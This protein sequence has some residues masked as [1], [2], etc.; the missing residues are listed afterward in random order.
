M[1]DPNTSVVV[2]AVTRTLA[3]DVLDGA[4]PL[5]QLDDAATM[6]EFAWA[7][8][9]LCFS[10]WNSNPQQ[11]LQ[12][13]ELL[14]ALRQQQHSIAAASA[15][16]ELAALE[17]WSR[18]LAFVVRGEMALAVEGF[19]AAAA[20]FRELGYALHAAQTQVAKIMALSMLGRYDAASDC[21]HAA[22]SEFLRLNDTHAAAKV[23]L[24]LGAL[25]ERRGDFAQAADH[26]RRAAV[27]FARAG[28]T[29]HS[30]MADINMAN[31][32]SSLG[33]F[34]EAD[35]MYA[36]AR[37]RAEVHRFPKLQTL[38][39]E[40]AAL[41]YLARGN[42][43]EA[44]A[45][46][47]R[48]R[49]CYE[50]LDLP[51]PLAIVEKQLADTYLELR[52]LPEAKALL[53]NAMRRFEAQNIP[54]E[55]AW[56]LSQ[57]GRVEALMGDTAA[58]AATLAQ[59][60]NLFGLQ[61]NSAGISAVALARAE[62]SLRTDEL[63]SARAFADE[64]VAGYSQCG[65]TEGRLRAHLVTAHVNLA[66][67][68]LDAALG[69]FHSV[70]DEAEALRLLSIQVR[71]L[72]GRGLIATRRGDSNSAQRDFAGAT[73]IFEAQ[74]QALPG[75]DLR[76][77]FLTDHLRPYQE[78]LRLALA[79]HETQ[80]TDQ[81]ARLALRR[82]DDFRART[83]SERVAENRLKDRNRADEDASDVLAMRTRLSWLN[84]Q[85]H[86]LDL[87]GES[88]GVLAEELRATE[89][90]LLE[91][92][93]RERMQADRQ[94]AADREPGDAAYIDRLPQL[95]G[96]RTAVVAYGVLDDELFAIVVAGGKIHIVRRMASWQAVIAA[97][98]A[99]QFQ[100]EALGT[101][102]PNMQK[103]LTTL[104]ARAQ[105][106]LQ[107]L[108]KLL[109]A[110]LTHLLESRRRIAVVPHAELG[111]VPFAALHDGC[112][113]L[114]QHHEISIVPSV[115]FAEQA[116]AAP[117]HHP[118]RPLLVADQE[119][120]QYAEIEVRAIAAIAQDGDVLVGPEAS[121]DRVC[122]LAPSTGIL[123]FACHARF[124][125]DNPRFSALALHDGALS[126]EAIE[127]LQL[128]PSTVVLSGCETGLATT[129]A[130][131][132][133]VGLFRAFLIA[134][135]SRVIA[136]LWRVD[137][138][139]TASFMTAFYRALYDGARP[140]AALNAAQRVV[141]QAHPHPYYW[142]PFVLY[143]AW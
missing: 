24:N 61:K 123:H 32:L 35:R 62:L 11:G 4:T 34:D 14:T 97:L 13:A 42:Y 3:A 115:R 41:L 109:W 45:G 111:T 104:T 107:A 12:A 134:G 69:V 98:R 79:Q 74:R 47:E 91:R 15:L 113:C 124:R 100:L 63:L 56:A 75:A 114:A 133:V 26:S 55:Q 33:D 80:A 90:A 25:N 112:A 142:A 17:A 108:H 120:L 125:Y 49:S 84:R 88:P 54:D 76:S 2:S 95:A 102:A 57:R 39:D 40:S 81:A 43:G 70:Q 117:Y 137:D 103:H 51:Q 119:H 53:E 132:E 23:A 83:L 37:K 118:S 128:G 9:D 64:A 92:L 106:R 130:G 29:E 105:N 116:L 31:A 27:Y 86:Q 60:A 21:A 94:R 138:R 30:I 6:L 96:D 5:P 78:L 73:A 19:D 136:S 122:E 110:P 66:L 135:A 99:T 67:G 101:G 46:F 77:A 59:A 82:L 127:Q 126:A 85:V 71:C 141:M 38:A 68:E 139:T 16:T 36:R 140:A 22:Q 58:A 10:T 93:R 131:D 72:T 87:A 1:S 28:D 20:G 44:L 129:T 89:H 48:A 52:L 18:G 143:G 50:Q 121:V 8:R 7:L 65:L